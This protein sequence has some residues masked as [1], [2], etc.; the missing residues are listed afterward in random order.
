MKRRTLYMV[1]RTRVHLDHVEELGQFLEIEVEL[2]DNEP[3]EAGA[4][5]AY[6]L[7]RTFGVESSALVEGSYVDL[8]QAPIV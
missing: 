1:G 7:M 8:L 5:E 6:D 4:R 3:A 2:G